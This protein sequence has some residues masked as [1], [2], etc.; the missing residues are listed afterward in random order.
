MQYHCEAVGVYSHNLSKKEFETLLYPVEHLISIPVEKQHT[1]YL[2]FEAIEK[3]LEQDSD[4]L[5]AYQ[6]WKDS[7][8]SDVK[9][10]PTRPVGLAGFFILVFNRKL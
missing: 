4:K 7:L 10:L 5:I 1:Y 6:E 8:A 2:V 3:E 9:Y